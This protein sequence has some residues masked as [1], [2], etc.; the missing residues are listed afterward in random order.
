MRIWY[1]RGSLTYRENKKERRR[2]CH[3][4]PGQGGVSRRFVHPS[5]VA[6]WRLCDLALTSSL[7]ADPRPP[8]AD[9][10]AVARRRRKVNPGYSSLNP[11]C[12]I[13]LRF[14]PLAPS[15]PFGSCPKSHQ[16]APN[17]VRR[18]SLN[19]IINPFF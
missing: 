13:L 1:S 17:M 11:G 15:L 10:S 8:A 5:R 3:V 9:L 19:P 6:S 2:P 18:Q 14:P 12:P 16:I 7:G 4:Q